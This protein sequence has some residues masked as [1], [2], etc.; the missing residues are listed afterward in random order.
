MHGEGPTRLSSGRRGAKSKS[1]LPSHLFDKT[2]VKTV[3]TRVSS[4]GTEPS[5]DELQLVVMGET[6]SAAKS[7][8]SVE[9]GPSESGSCEKR[10]IGPEGW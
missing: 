3:G 10:E 1:T 6:G 9:C 5:D 8:E 4:I 2:I 7:M